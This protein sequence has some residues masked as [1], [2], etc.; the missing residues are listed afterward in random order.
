MMAGVG[1]GTSCGHG[2]LG[3][4]NAAYADMKA[5]MGTPMG[6]TPA[7]VPAEGM[8]LSMGASAHGVSANVFASGHSQNCGNVMT[9]RSTTRVAQAPGGTSS[10]RFY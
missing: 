5:A 2:G 10:I 8:S 4:N 7:P 3:A 6:G 1:A 9:G